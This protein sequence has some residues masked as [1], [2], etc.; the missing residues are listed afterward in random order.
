[1]NMFVM[2]LL[3]CT[4]KENTEDT[5][6]TTDTGIETEE[7]EET[8]TGTETEEITGTPVTFNLSDAEGMKI[9][10][11]RVEFNDEGIGFADNQVVT[12]ELGSD[13]SFTIGVETPADEELS[14]M[15]PENE[16]LIGMW[17][18]YLFQ[19][20][21]GDDAYTEGEEIAGIGRTWLVYSTAALAE[22]NVDEGWSALEMTFSE[23]PPIVGDLAS[24]PLDASLRVNESITIGGS[25]DTALGERR[26]AIVAAATFDSDSVETMYDEVATDPWTLTLSGVPADN[27]FISEEEFQGAMGSPLV[28]PDTNN[29][30]SFESLDLLGQSSLNTICFDGMSNMEPQPISI[31]YYP[32]P[33]DLSA[34]LTTS[35]Y[36]I[37]AGW[38]VMVDT[39][40]DPYFPSQD[41]FNNMVIDENCILE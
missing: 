13:T 28:Y 1:M 8:D 35:I 38:I 3:A 12:S 15:I 5:G 27:H 23:E 33:T 9:G 16:T 30:G 29:N 31:I 18:P 37:G 22:F 41:E 26:I 34:A 36:G 20:S 11:L 10:L 2:L 17:A 19:D 24:V 25:Y 40:S 39:G 4:E 21:D 32:P 6:E 7:E 14:A